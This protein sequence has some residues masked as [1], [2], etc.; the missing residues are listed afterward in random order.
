[1][2]VGRPHRTSLRC[3]Q[4]ATSASAQPCTEP[5]RDQA[6][7]GGQA[8]GVNVPRLRRTL[9]GSAVRRL[10]LASTVRAIVSGVVDQEVPDEGVPERHQEDQ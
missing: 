7:G 5:G 3:G 10:W 8:T 2:L 4:R 1:M 6:E 9:S